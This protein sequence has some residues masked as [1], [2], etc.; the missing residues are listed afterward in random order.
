MA[1]NTVKN[2]VKYKHF[3]PK[4]YAP[5]NVHQ[6]N[7]CTSFKKLFKMFMYKFRREKK[8]N[9]IVYKYSKKFLNV[10]GHY[11]SI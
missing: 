8:S 6:N 4:V 10:K 5:Q 2:I 1:F 7:N 9:G 11:I 3:S